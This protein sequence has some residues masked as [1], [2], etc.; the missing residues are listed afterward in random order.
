MFNKKGA[1]L[2]MNTI[3]ISIIV[4]VVLVIVIVFFL[5]GAS[6]ITQKISGIFTGATAGIDLKLATQFCNNYCEQGNTNAFCK[7]AFKVDEDE[8][9][10]TPAT[11]YRCSDKSR[12]N[13]LTIG[14]K[15]YEY[16]AMTSI[17]DDCSNIETC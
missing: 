6:S 12:P 13:A 5:G 16:N 1:E 2:P 10:S 8:D 7:K 4:I 14:T 11:A 15:T 17:G 3:I 9:S